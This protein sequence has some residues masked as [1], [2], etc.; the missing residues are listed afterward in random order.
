[1]TRRLV[2]LLCVA[3]LALSACGGGADEGSGTEAGGTEA[4]AGSEAAAPAEEG[5]G[6]GGEVA[7]RWRTRPDNQAEIDV[8][9]D[10]SNTIDESLEGVTLEY[11]AGTSETSS[12]QDVLKT[13]IASGTAPDVFW[14]PGTD[15]AD[16]V[17]RGLLLDL[18]E[19]ASAS[20]DYSDEA[21]YP[22]P[23]EYLTFDPES[24]ESGGPLWGLP[25]DVSTMVLYL[26]MDLINE[27]GAPD[28]RELAEAGE[29]NWDSFLE[30]AQAVT[31]LGG[32]IKG[33]GQNAWWGPYGY[34]INAAGGSFFNEDRTACAVDSPEAVQGLE[35]FS[36]LYNQYDVAVPYGEDAE[37]PFLAGQVGMFQNGRWATPG[38]R[39]GADFT[40]DVVKLPDGPGGPS[41]WLFWGAYAVNADTEHPEEA[42][43]LVQQL[44]ST[45]TQQTI[46]ELGANIPSRVDEEAQEQFLS[47][48]PPENTQAFLQGLEEDPQTEGPLWAGDWVGFDAALGPLVQS[49]VTGET[50]PDA[51]AE[52]A[53]SEL[54]QYFE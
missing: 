24:G 46:A 2:L 5:G 42:W 12:Y 3:A 45:E 30:V 39:S 36:S 11:E 20:E 48:T 51:F 9:S 35:F 32:G 43:Q 37:P 31:D 40:Y 4:A 23:M 47:F 49:V 25:R 27:A 8:Y 6:E 50:T 13:E 54:S 7:L 41:N 17:E 18:R 26:N 1:M 52:S 34:W 38:V 29:W 14:I 19:Y 16:F 33:Y 15:V 21:F 53:C 10:V 28:P 22:G 44:T